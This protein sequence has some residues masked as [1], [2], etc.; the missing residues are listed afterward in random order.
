MPLRELNVCLL[1]I[2]GVTVT[3]LIP[4]Q[5]LWLWAIGVL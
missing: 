1:I 5:F 2:A 3:V 4:L